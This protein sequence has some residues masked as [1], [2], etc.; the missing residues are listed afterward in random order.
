MSVRNTFLEI[1]PEVL[2]ESNRRLDQ[3]ESDED[4]TILFAIESG[5]RAWGFPSPDSDYDVR[6]VYARTR[7]WYLSIIPGRDVIELPIEGVYDINGW[8]LKKALQLLCKPNPVLLEWMESPIVYREV[9]WFM[10]RLRELADLTLHHQAGTHHYLHLAKGQY[11][12]FIDGQDE[13]ALKK[14]FYSLRP[15]L[16]LN[17]L[18]SNGP[19]R[20]PM[21]VP[22]LLAGIELAD[23]V[24]DFIFDL[25]ERKK[26]TKELGKG[27]RIPTLDRY[28]EGEI[29]KASSALPKKAIPKDRIFEAANRLFRDVLN[30]KIGA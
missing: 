9:P 30:V 20:V 5:S 10:G 16:A 24:R 3:V 28:I 14:Y 13:V 15:A 19:E 1:D 12:R 23:E 8:D 18:R 7:D 25:M 6:F 27:P 11:Q 21:S 17:W 2:A 29:D 22:E 26:T 4:A